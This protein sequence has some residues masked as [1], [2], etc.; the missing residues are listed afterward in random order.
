MSSLLEKIDGYARQSGIA[1]MLCGARGVICAFSGGAD[2]SVLLRFLNEF[3]EDKVKLYAAHLN[4]MIRGEESDSDERFCRRT[5]EELGIPFITERAD[6]PAEA[7]AAGEGLE[8]CAR[9]IRYEFFAR[10]SEKLGGAAVATA[11]NATDNLETVIFNLARGS[12]TRGM[13]GI[14]PIRGIYVRPMLCCTSEEI[15]AFAQSNGISYVT[16]ST[17]SCNDYTRNYI[18]H[19]IVPEMRRLNPKADEAALRMSACARGDSEYL[20]AAAES[21]LCGSD[22]IDRAEAEKLPEALFARVLFKLYKCCTNSAADL[23]DAHIKSCRALIKS[24][25]GSVSLPGG[26]SFFAHK[27]KIFIAPSSLAEPLPEPTVLPLAGETDFGAWHISCIEEIYTSP[28]P[29]REACAAA[30]GKG[31]AGCGE[32][33]QNGKKSRI[34]YNLYIEKNS[35]SD[36]IKGALFVRCR[37]A[38]DVLL[39][40]GMHKKLKKLLCDKCVPLTERDTLPII[41]DDGGIVAV[42]GVGVRDGLTPRKNNSCFHIIIEKRVK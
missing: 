29:L 32:L 5:C 6:V 17:N 36:K 27:D 33:Y 20:D 12:G 24:G 28:A 4:P 15:R 37:E 10:L 31:G 22:H 8:E 30:G 34:I 42:P 9:R 18:R 25:C 14:A 3:C 35:V 7:A 21:Y 13:A 26:C 1:E 2:S 41:C 23:S 19:T 40:G 38:G 11:H 39:S 16:D